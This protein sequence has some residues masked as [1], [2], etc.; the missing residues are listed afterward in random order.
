M[1]G[2]IKK[3]MEKG[4]GFITP[5]GGGK[6]IFFHMTGLKGSK[7]DDIR[8]GNEVDYDTENGEKGLKAVNVRL[9]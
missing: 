9:V 1:T 5:A 7:W 8:E 6:D 3:K 4:F 2:S